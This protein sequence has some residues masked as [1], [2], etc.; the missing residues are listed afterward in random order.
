VLDIVA[1]HKNEAPAPID[2]RVIDN[3]EPRLPAAQRSTAKP[4]RAEAAH[5]PCGR[6][7][8]PEHDDEREQE[9]DREG[10][11]TEERHESPSVWAFANGPSRWLT[12]PVTFA[13]E[14]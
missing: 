10:H 13:G 1:A 14:W 2:A 8:Q 7:D 4:A 6:T 3:R 5:H 9:L 12:P 11:T